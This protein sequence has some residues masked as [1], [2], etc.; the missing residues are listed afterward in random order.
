MPSYYLYR[1]T[2]CGHEEKRYRNSTRCQKCGGRIERASKNEQVGKRD[3]LIRVTF[4]YDASRHQRLHN[5]L[6]SVEHNRSHEI[7]RTLLLG[8]DAE[9]IQ[10][11]SMELPDYEQTIQEVVSEILAEIQSLRGNHTFTQVD[12]TPARI[13]ST[14]SSDVLGNLRSLG[15][16]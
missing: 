6:Q 16:E 10:L 8:L 13:T 1:C 15:T 12:A 4:V 11:R 9:Q 5:W 14:V 7:R 2:E 3:D